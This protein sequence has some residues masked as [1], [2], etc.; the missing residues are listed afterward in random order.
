MSLG[1]LAM[2][3]LY[4]FDVWPILIEEYFIGTLQNILRL[5]QDFSNALII[6]KIFFIMFVLSFGFK[7]TIGHTKSISGTFSGW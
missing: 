5:F 6:L 3:T 7:I 1:F 4:I 2:E